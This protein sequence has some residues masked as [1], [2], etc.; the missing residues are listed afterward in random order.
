MEFTAWLPELWD[1]MLPIDRLSDRMD[2]FPPPKDCDAAD[3]RRG[4]DVAVDE[5]KIVEIFGAD[6]FPDE[7]LAERLPDP[8]LDERLADVPVDAAM[9][10]YAAD[11][12]DTV[13]FVKTELSDAPFE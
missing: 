11:E 4:C 9:P 5:E 3:G 7:T 12:G 1:D 2:A 10:E 6:T 8:P 13:L